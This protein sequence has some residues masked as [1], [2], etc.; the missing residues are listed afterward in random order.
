ME[1]SGEGAGKAC[2]VNEPG[3]SVPDHS[4]C[5]SGRCVD[6]RKAPRSLTT[7]VDESCHSVSALAH[8]T[9]ATF[10]IGDTPGLLQW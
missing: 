7:K 9:A 4:R 3:E 10:T 5:W 6:P 1:L 8:A 2:L